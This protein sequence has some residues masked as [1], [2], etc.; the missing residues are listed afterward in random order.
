MSQTELNKAFSNISSLKDNLPKSHKINEKYVKIFNSEIDRLTNIGITSIEEYKI[1][2]QDL[3]NEFLGGNHMTGE[4]RYSDEK[5]IER[6]LFLYKIDAI[7]TFFQLE[8][9]ET[10]MGFRLD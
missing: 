8:A 5:Y 2:I 10:K 1:P 7:L 4:R 3:G 6:N 9:S